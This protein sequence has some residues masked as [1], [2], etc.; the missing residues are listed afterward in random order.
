MIV[1]SQ[2]GLNLIETNRL[3][4]SGDSDGPCYVNAHLANGNRMV[5]AEF[6]KLEYAK[7]YIHRVW[8]RHLS[9]MVSVYISDEN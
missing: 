5:I 2:D 7:N 1:L 8:E 3:S 4:V 6:A 9:P